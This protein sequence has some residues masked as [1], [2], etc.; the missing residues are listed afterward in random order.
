[1]QV[2]RQTRARTQIFG[3][4]VET[5]FRCTNDHNLLQTGARQAA[6]NKWI[7]LGVN[8]KEWWGLWRAH[9]PS[10]WVNFSI[11]LAHC[12]QGFW[13]F[14]REDRNKDFYVRSLGLKILQQIHTL[15]YRWNKSVHHTYSAV[16]PPVWNLCA[17]F[18]KMFF[19]MFSAMDCH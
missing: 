10:K 8:I 11:A 15:L 3:L 19:L 6:K 9:I 1:M 4:S 5:P 18:S 16:D 7:G 12:C 2:C 17:S 13:F 14:S